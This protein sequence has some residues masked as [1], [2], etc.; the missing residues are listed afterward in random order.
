MEGGREGYRDRYTE[1]WREIM[2]RVEATLG[3][4]VTR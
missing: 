3:K 2:E 4:M 1:G